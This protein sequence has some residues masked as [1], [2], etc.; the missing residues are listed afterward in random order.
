[1]I[2]EPAQLAGLDQLL[3][4][5]RCKKT[6][7]Q[8]ATRCTPYPWDTPGKKIVVC[9]C[10]LVAD[11]EIFKAQ[12]GFSP[13]PYPPRIHPP[14]MQGIRAAACALKT[15]DYLPPRTSPGA[16]PFPFA[17][18]SL[19]RADRIKGDP[20][21]IAFFLELQISRRWLS[22]IVSFHSPGPISI[23]KHRIEKAEI[24]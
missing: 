3:S 19:D 2:T 1:M 9:V 11:D 21:P 8:W 15:L 7:S 23:R 17:E 10:V 6:L 24:S 4:S 18:R 16:L 5:T 20:L 13:P 22:S 14:P 12:K